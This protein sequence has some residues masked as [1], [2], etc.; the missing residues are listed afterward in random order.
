MSYLGDAFACLALWAFKKWK[1]G[2]GKESSLL[3]PPA[4]PLPCPPSAAQ[5]LILCTFLAGGPFNYPPRNSRSARKRIL[6]CA[7]TIAQGGG[8]PESDWGG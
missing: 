5:T 4:V 2:R 7:Q 8:I 6:L 3:L 1:K